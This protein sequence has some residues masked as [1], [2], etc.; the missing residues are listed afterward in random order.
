MPPLP[1]TAYVGTYAD[2]LYG[3]ATVSIKD[4]QLELVRGDWHAPLEYLERD[5]LPVER[6]IGDGA[7]VHQV[8][9][10]R[11]TTPSPDCISVSAATSRC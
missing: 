5:E 8:R 11:R 2:S 1:L 3:E 9:G 4:G 7:D 10:R 6:L